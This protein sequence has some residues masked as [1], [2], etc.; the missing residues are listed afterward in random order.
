[1]AIVDAN[2]GLTHAL[3]AEWP[4]IR[5]QRCTQHKLRKLRATA[6]VRLRAELTEDYRRLLYGR[7]VAVVE[8][9]RAGFTKKY[10]LRCPA[11]VESLKEAHRGAAVRLDQNR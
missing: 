4:G 10:Q 6:P 8:Q 5:I 1:L 11:L 9:G 2:P 7:T 3:L